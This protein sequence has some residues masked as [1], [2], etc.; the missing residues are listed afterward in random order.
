MSVIAKR[1]AIFRWIRDQLAQIG[2][3]GFIQRSPSGDPDVFPAICI[4]DGGHV[5]DVNTEPGITRYALSVII[6]GYVETD[7]GDE[8]SADMN[9][10]YLDVIAKLITDPP[11]GGLAESID[12]GALRVDVALLASKRRMGF[13]LDVPITFAAIR[14]SPS[15]EV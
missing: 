2:G 4:E 8:A 11:C 3:L 1:E 5:P 9:Q 14:Q 15:T 7:F 13:S 10:L 6:E 12:E